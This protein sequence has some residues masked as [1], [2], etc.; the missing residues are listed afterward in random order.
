MDAHRD[1]AI[2]NKLTT[3]RQIAQQSPE[4]RQRVETA[5]AKCLTAVL[6]ED[7]VPPTTAQVV[8]AVI[9]SRST[10]EQI[11]GT[12]IF[13]DPA[14]DMLLDLYVNRAEGRET[15][16][17]SL[18]IAGG[19]PATT[20]LR[21]VSSMEE[22]GF[23]KRRKDHHDARRVLIDPDPLAM[24]GVERAVSRLSTRS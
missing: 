21:Y 19:V 17:S 23:L 12:D 11:F 7:Y 6:S 18:C 22:L 24:T 5:L 10:R 14:W 20:G 8:K 1:H 9:K 3:L 4:L 13:R 15:S 16:V 2:D